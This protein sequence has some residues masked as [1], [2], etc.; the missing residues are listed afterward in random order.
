MRVVFLAV[1]DE[2]AGLMQKHLY[3]RHKD[4]IVGSVIS[5]SFVYRKSRLGAAAFLIRHSG[6][7]YVA[8]MIKMKIIRKLHQR[9]QKL[10]PTALAKRHQVEQYRTSNINGEE[11]LAKLRSWNPQ[12]MISTNFS[13]YVGKHARGIPTVGAWNLHKSHL[14]QY[15]GMAPNFHALLEGATSVGATLHVLAKGFDTGDILIQVDVPVQEGDTVYELNKR[16]ADAGGRMLVEFLEGL[17]P[18]NVRAIPQPEGDWRN[19]TYPTRAE[20]RAFR[21]QG[22]RF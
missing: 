8:Q 4:W 3:E 21:R 18:G 14:P 15:R 11:S 6:F 20:L 5:S 22:G 7:G 9:G 13:Q 16:T 19:Y 17:D 1:D 2:F 10:F 12:V